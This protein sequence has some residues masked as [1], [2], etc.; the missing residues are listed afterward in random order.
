MIIA[1]N[2]RNGS[3]II[4]N[5]EPYRVLT[6]KV[7][8][9]GRQGNSISVKMKNILNG[10]LVENRWATDEKIEETEVLF[11][12]MEFLYANGDEFVFMNQKNYEQIS[13]TRSDLEDVCGYLTPNLPC[14]VQFYDGRAI[15][16]SVPN[17]VQLKVAETEP[18]IK[19]ASATGKVTKSATL[20]T[21]LVVQVPMFVERDDTVI[22]GTQTG[23]YQGRPGRG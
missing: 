14:E 17:T 6:Y 13:M 3:I 12:S 10:K 23:E 4:Y 2:I 18:G 11:E 1:G 9:Q 8:V 15:G 5:G 7:T 19:G 16:V 20:E 22:I 21:G